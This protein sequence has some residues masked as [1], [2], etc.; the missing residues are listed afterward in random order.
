MDWPMI[1]L[2]RQSDANQKP[3]IVTKVPELKNRWRFMTVN[4]D[5]DYGE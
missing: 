1:D 4:L 2:T 3:I 5:K